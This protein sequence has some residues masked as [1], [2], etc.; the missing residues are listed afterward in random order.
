MEKWLQGE[1]RRRCDLCAGAG[2]WACHPRPAPSQRLSLCTG[3]PHTT[4]R[5]SCSPGLCRHKG[6]SFTKTRQT[7]FFGC[8]CASRPLAPP[9]PD[10]HTDT[11]THSCSF[12]GRGSEGTFNPPANSFT[13][14][15]KKLKGDGRLYFRSL[16]QALIF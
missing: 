4:G 3:V 15:D 9:P 7:D 13:S 6:L 11:D 5:G 8:V 12:R 1:E 16:K 2:L 14:Q 10:I